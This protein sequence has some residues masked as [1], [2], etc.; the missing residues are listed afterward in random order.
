V[1]SMH[2]HLPTIL[3]FFIFLTAFNVF[4]FSGKYAPDTGHFSP[5]YNANCSEDHTNAVLGSDR[6]HIYAGKP[7]WGSGPLRSSHFCKGNM[8]GAVGGKYRVCLFTNVCWNGDGIT[9]YSGGK[10]LFTYYD[11]ELVGPFD[12]KFIRLNTE[13]EDPSYLNITVANAYLPLGNTTFFESTIAIYYDPYISENF[14]HFLAEGL[15]AAYY[16]QLMFGVLTPDVSLIVPRFVTPNC[17]KHT[18]CSLLFREWAPG[19]TRKSI[20]QLVDIKPGTCF[21]ELI[22]GT[23]PLSGLRPFSEPMVGRGSVW[24]D[25]REY[26]LRNLGFNP[27]KRPKIHKILWSTRNPSETRIILNQQQVHTSLIQE[28]PHI[29]LEVMN[30][31]LL[32]STQQLKLLETTTVLITPDGGISFIAALLPLGS[33][34]V[35]LDDWYPLENRS[36]HLEGFLWSFIPNHLQDFYYLVKARETRMRRGDP[37]FLHAD[38]YVDEKRLIRVVRAALESVNSYYQYQGF[39]PLL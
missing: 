9:Y 25:F 7:I 36:R 33:A 4:F 35:F 39:P 23:W 15:F 38:I 16:A 6:N 29:P 10:D 32:N 13:R 8:D 28:F 14:G 26:M 22:P 24:Y 34:A 19:I 11:R 27:L 37:N 18:R 3:A 31:A 30:I 20:K 12:K 21:Q 5:H 2:G 17:K 1:R